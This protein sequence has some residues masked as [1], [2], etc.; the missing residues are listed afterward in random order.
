[1]LEVRPHAGDVEVGTVEDQ[2]RGRPVEP[3]HQRLVGRVAGRGLGAQGVE[4]GGQHV[5][6][7]AQPASL[8]PRR[9]LGLGDGVTH[10]QGLA[11]ARR[12]DHRHP[13]GAPDRGRETALDLFP[14]ET[15]LQ[16]APKSTAAGAQIRRSTDADRR[17]SPTG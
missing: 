1:V 11:A 16:H 8:D 3:A 5:V 2:D 15:R 7:A 14:P 13:P 4:A 6:Q 12:T 17:R 9:L 10:E